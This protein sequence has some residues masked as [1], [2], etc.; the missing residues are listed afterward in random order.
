M[1]LFVPTHGGPKTR[2]VFVIS[3]EREAEEAR[4]QAEEEAAK[5]ARE[6]QVIT[7][8]VSTPLRC[9]SPMSSVAYVCLP[10][11]V[12]LRGECI[13]AAAAMHPGR[14]YSNVTRTM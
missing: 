2:F 4:A 8:Y 3:Q 14:E 10:R 11:L 9:P 13:A 12:H 6:E 5:L 7:R 1:N